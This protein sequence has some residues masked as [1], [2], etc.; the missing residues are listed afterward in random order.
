MKAM[1]GRIST[2]IENDADDMIDTTADDGRWGELPNWRGGNFVGE[3]HFAMNLDSIPTI[4]CLRS[5]VVGRLGPR[6]VAL[7]RA[8]WLNRNSKK[9]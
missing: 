5:P 2:G 6:R 1:V 7:L 4:G 8:S 9:I 3:R